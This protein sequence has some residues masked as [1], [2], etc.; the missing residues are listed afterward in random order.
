[1]PEVL[2]PGPHHPAISD[3][4]PKSGQDFEAFVQGRTFETHDMSARYGVET[5][6]PGRRAI[7]RDA[8]QCLDGSL[9][10]VGDM[11]CFDDIG[12]PQPSCWTYHG[13]G[14]YLMVWINGVRRTNPIMRYPADEVLTCKG[15]FGV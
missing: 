4:P 14:D 15:Y 3:A 13:R 1:V 5:F 10:A 2:A 12:R 11:I 9:R 7:W 6:L 8:A